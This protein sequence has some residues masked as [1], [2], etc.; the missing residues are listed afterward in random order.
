MR[1]SESYSCLNFHQSDVQR[2]AVAA[3]VVA[4]L[5]LA[6]LGVAAA[7]IDTAVEPDGGGFG[8][9]G[10][11]SRGVGPDDPDSL[12]DDAPAAST[13]IAPLFE[14]IPWLR[15]PPALAGLALL[16]ALFFGLTY[17]DTGSPFAGVM[18]AGALFMPIG[19]LWVVFAFCSTPEALDQDL[20]LGLGNETEGELFG[21]A[22]GSSGLGGTG[23]TVSTP[24][25]LFA[26]LLVVALVAS[27]VLLIT[28]GRDDDAGAVGG[29]SA[30]DP[31]EP[32]EATALGRRAG[33]AADRIE[34][35]ADVDN[36]VF[37]AWRE[38]TDA[39]AVERPQSTTPTEFADAAVAAGVDRDDAEALTA[40]FEEVRYGGAAPTE[41]R[42]RR[43]VAALRRI[44]AAYADGDD[45]E[46]A[47]DGGRD[48]ADVPA[49][50]SDRRAD[51]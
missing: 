26:V 47:T 13:Q 50:G 10:G 45:A 12:G 32:P 43:A 2:D 4:L 20:R 7:T 34:A 39:L 22:G 29:P 42:E 33:A 14:C 27:A 51:R 36:E 9:G 18:V 21:E 8:G 28:A 5:A 30:D 15:S 38:M 31:E 40:L 1:P 48:S 25:A 16:F 44:E 19:L 24:T 46:V 6:A 49:R 41:D 17:R 11:E 23:E 35:D 37:R 3:V